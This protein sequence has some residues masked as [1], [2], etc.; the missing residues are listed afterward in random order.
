[1]ED[2]SKFVVTLELFPGTQA[3]RRKLDT[4]LEIAGDAFQDGRISAVSITD[5]PG[6]N[7][8]LAPDALG[9]EIFRRGMDVIIHFTCRDMNRGGMRGR[10]MQLAMMGMRNILA[11]N[12]D[13]TSHSGEQGTPVFDL[14]SVKILLFFCQRCGDCGLQ[15]LAFQCPESGCPKHTRNGACG[16]SRNG[17][18]EVRPEQLCVWVRAYNRWSSTGRV[19]EMYSDCIQPRMWILNRSSSWLNFHL[20]RDHQSVSSEI[21]RYCSPVKCRLG[22]DRQN[23]D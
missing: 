7:P 20:G 17:K 1:M 16:G 19:S 11:I 18:C 15:H 2:P 4:V 6:G 23:E 5:N 13:Y 3:S 12:G 22:E 9:L 10:T 8:S 21:T 14:D